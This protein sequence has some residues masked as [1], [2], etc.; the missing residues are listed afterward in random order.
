MEK[1][2]LVCDWCGKEVA[3]SKEQCMNWLI[4]TSYETQTDL[5]S[6]DGTKDTEDII[7]V[8]KHFCSTKCAREHL[9]DNNG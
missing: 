1:Y 8:N 9:G 2:S 3:M 6:F 5:S 7:Q 4:I